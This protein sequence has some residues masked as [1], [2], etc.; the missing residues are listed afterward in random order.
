MKGGINFE[1]KAENTILHALV[2]TPK[3]LIN[4]FEMLPDGTNKTTY[5]RKKEKTRLLRE[6][7]HGGLEWLVFLLACETMPFFTL[8]KVRCSILYFDKSELHVIGI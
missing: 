8:G 5:V 6:I 4:I 3:H 2:D 1:L 7:Q